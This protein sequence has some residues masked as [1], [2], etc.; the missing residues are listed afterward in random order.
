MINSDH[1]ILI[2]WL[3]IALIFPCNAS[4]QLLFTPVLAQIC[5]RLKTYAS[6][7][8]CSC[9]YLWIPSFNRLLTFLRLASKNE[10]RFDTEGS[11]RNLN[12]TNQTGSRNSKTNKRFVKTAIAFMRRR[13]VEKRR[14]NSTAVFSFSSQNLWFLRSCQGFIS[15]NLKDYLSIPGC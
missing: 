7:M 11:F 5:H 9:W 3:M 6:I 14:R 12:T 1:I 15:L 2:T 4:L 8:A 10:F 13:K